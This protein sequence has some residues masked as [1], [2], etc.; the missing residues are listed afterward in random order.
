[1]NQIIEYLGW[2]GALLVAKAKIV[3][4]VESMKVRQECVIKQMHIFSALQKPV[5]VVG[6]NRVFFFVSG[7]FIVLF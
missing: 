1:M 6:I 2:K 7:Q 3:L 5:E 4:S